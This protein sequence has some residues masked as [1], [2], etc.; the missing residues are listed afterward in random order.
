MR[1]LASKLWL[2]T[3]FIQASKPNNLCRTQAEPL[4]M[5]AWGAKCIKP[6]QARLQGN[7]Q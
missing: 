1:L 5:A 6:D 4:H 3:V 2:E 7:H